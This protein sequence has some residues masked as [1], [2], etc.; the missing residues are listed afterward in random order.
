MIIDATYNNVSVHYHVTDKNDLCMRGVI[1]MLRTYTPHGTYCY[2]GQTQTELHKRIYDHCQDC[3]KRNDNNKKANIINKYKEIHVFIVAQS[4]DANAL[5]RLERIHI[6]ECAQLYGRMCM[7][8]IIAVTPMKERITVNKIKSEFEIQQYSLDGRFIRV[9]RSIRDAEYYTGVSR[10][11]IGKAVNG[12]FKTAGGYQWKRTR[13]AKQITPTKSHISRQRKTSRLDAAKPNRISQK[14]QRCVE[15]KEEKKIRE[16]RARGRKIEQYD[17]QGNY[18]TTFPSLHEAASQTGVSIKGITNCCIGVFPQS[19][20]FQFRYKNSNLKVRCGLI[21]GKEKLAKNNTEQKGIKI[22]L[23]DLSHKVVGV[24]PSINQ[25]SK[26][27]DVNVSTLH[28]HVL[29]ITAQPYKGYYFEM[30]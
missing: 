9:F 5:D 14:T 26:Y 21:S 13:D 3:N 16:Q 6:M 7:N 23:C 8:T 18:I 29:N 17:L 25:L 28:H 11:T 4:L 19:K 20:G 22:R 1:Y 30:I 2:I 10:A 27:M 24:F 12:K 15:T